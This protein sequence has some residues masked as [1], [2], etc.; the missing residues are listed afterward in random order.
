MD[1]ELECE[2]QFLETDFTGKQKEKASMI[3]MAKDESL[4]TMKSC[5]HL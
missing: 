2:S 4:S 3:P 1:W 5:L